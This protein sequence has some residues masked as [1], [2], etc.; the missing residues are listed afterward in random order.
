MKDFD[1]EKFRAIS[2]PS[3]SD[4]QSNWMNK[5]SQHGKHSLYSI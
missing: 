2:L 4:I 5:K 3:Q 1:I